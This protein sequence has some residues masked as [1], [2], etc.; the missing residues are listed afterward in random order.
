MD[1]DRARDGQLYK[2]PEI[3]ILRTLINTAQ[4]F[5]KYLVTHIL[6]YLLNKVFLVF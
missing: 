3:K 2:K 6:F 4:K 5:S 1:V